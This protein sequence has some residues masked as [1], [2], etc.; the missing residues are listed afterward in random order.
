MILSNGGKF[1][2]NLNADE[3]QSMKEILKIGTSAGGVRLKALVAF[4]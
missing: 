4:T 3:Q 1:E 2:S